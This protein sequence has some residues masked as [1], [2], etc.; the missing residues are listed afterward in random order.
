MRRQTVDPVAKLKNANPELAGLLEHVETVADFGEARDMYDAA[1][2]MLHAQARMLAAGVA[3]S[4]AKSTH[5]LQVSFLAEMER[6]ASIEIAGSQVPL[7][8]EA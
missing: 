7:E 8:I 2:E 1:A 4:V 5:E 3:A 6:R